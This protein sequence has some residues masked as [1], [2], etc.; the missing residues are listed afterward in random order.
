[1]MRLTSGL[2]AVAVLEA[3]KGVLVVI[4]GFAVLAFIHAGMQRFV[5]EL[6]R[7]LH[8]NPAR[9]NPRI[10]LQLVDNLTDQ[11]LWMLALL[12]AAYSA[13]RFVEAYGLWCERRWAEWFAAASGGIYVPFE[14]YEM[15]KGISWIKL[16]ALTI[17]VVVVAYMIYVLWQSKRGSVSRL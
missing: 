13:A 7:L 4:A 16:T 14:I 3:T 5:E 8:L 10:F 9:G 17:N 1:M 15:L 2:R 11:R 12:A 6:V